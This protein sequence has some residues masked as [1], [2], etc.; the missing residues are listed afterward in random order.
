MPKVLVS[1][2]FKDETA[3]ARLLQTVKRFVPDL[4]GHFWADDLA[5]MA[6]TEARDQLLAKECGL[7][8]ILANPEELARPSVRT[9]L[10]LAALCVQSVKGQD[11]PVI[12]AVAGALP[13]PAGLPTPLAGAEILAADNAAL[14]PRVAAKA[15]TPRKP[16]SLEY[17]LDVYALPKLGLWFEAGP[18]PGHQWKGAMIGVDKGDIFA[19][20]VGPSGKLP[21]RSVVEYAMKGMK[22]GLG[23]REYTAWAVQNALEPGTSYYIGVRGEPSALVFGSLPDGDGAEVFSL[24]LT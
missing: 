6:W 10:A 20:G 16:A 18:G 12:L 8:L 23:D 24:R 17:R 13:E 9:G 21:E 15:F 4:G 19:H 14:G 22:L 5:N 3:A 11:F 7:W 2:L 1:A